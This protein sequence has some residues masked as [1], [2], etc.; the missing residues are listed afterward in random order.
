MAETKDESASENILANKVAI[1]ERDFEPLPEQEVDDEATIDEEETLE[2]GE[3]FNQ[4]EI[5]DLQKDA[6][7]PIEDLL[8]LYYTPT[9]EESDNVKLEDIQPE[10]LIHY[11]ND[12][13]DDDDEEED[14][15]DGD[16]DLKHNGNSSQVDIPQDIAQSP[17]SSTL[18]NCN[19][20]PL[21]N[22]RITRGLAAAYQ[23]FPDSDSSSSDEDYS[24]A[25]DW[26][27]EI[28]VG[29]EHQAIVP[30]TTCPHKNEKDDKYNSKCLWSPKGISQHKLQKYMDTVCGSGWDGGTTAISKGDDEQALYVLLQCNYDCD[31][32]L[33]KFKSQT[34]PAQAM[35]FWSEEECRNFELGLRQFGKDFISI[36]QSKIP[37]RTVGDIVQFYYLWKK[38]ERHDA[39]SCQ[40]RSKKKY[41]FY[42]GITDY[43]DRFFDENECAASSCTASPDRL[44]I[45]QSINEESVKRSH[46]DDNSS[47]SSSQIHPQYVQ[48]PVIVSQ[49]PPAKKPNLT[50]PLGIQ[51]GPPPLKS[52]DSLQVP[53]VVSHVTHSVVMTANYMTSPVTNHVLHASNLSNSAGG[54][55]YS[56][57]DGQHVNAMQSI[58]SGNNYPRLTQNS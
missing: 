13:C 45:S 24:P 32:A 36:Q 51:N 27:K 52:R 50:Q 19:V 10:P 1:N 57:L 29:P 18:P 7:V 40:L 39:F 20:N 17:H 46:D 11:D 56:L 3:G 30:E 53:H 14:D 34:P 33:K 35:T 22:Q 28:H 26:K 12:D 2:A 41:A 25:E 16:D 38:T 43:M 37:G 54:L 42:P 31:E 49:E 9:D 55:H 15:D 6:E 5:N 4:N 8:A 47:Q 23:Y 58:E 21:E 44:Q 48:T